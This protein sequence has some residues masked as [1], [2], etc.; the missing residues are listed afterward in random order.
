MSIQ[1]CRQTLISQDFL[2]TNYLPAMLKHY[3]SGWVIEYYVENPELLKLVR[4]RI[5]VNRIICRYDSKREAMKHVHGIV[6]ALNAKLAAGWNPFFCNDNTV[7][8]SVSSHVAMVSDSTTLSRNMG[9]STSLPTKEDPIVVPTEKRDEK[10]SSEKPSLEEERH[11]ISFNEVCTKYLEEIRRSLR[12]DTLRSYASFLKIFRE[13]VENK[14]GDAKCSDLSRALVVEFMENVYNRRKGRGGKDIS[15]RTYNG[16][17]KQGS[18]FFSWMID[19]C[20]IEDNHFSKI[21]AKRVG[22]KER[23]LIP[24][25]VREKVADYLRPRDPNYLLFLQ[26]IFAGLIRPKELGMLKVG[27]LSY[28]QGNIR[29]RSEVAKNG[30]E[31]IVPLSVDILQTFFNLR[32]HEYPSSYYIFGEG[33]KPTA[34][35]GSQLAGMKKWAKVRKAL[36]LPMEMQQYS[37][38]DTGITEMIKGGIDPLTVQ[39]L[40]DHSSLAVTSVYTKHKDPNLHEIIT[41]NAPKFTQ[42]DVTSE[43]KV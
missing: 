9:S 7:S 24:E 5:K 39:Q 30:H 37:F 13:W 29:V 15:P 12:P 25:D 31:R 20:Y 26:L 34:K 33:F 16:Y 11:N 43:V 2:V 42:C 4:K 27:D 21:K 18:A 35:R 40:A 32:I 3:D 1:N 23:E 38:R 10:K 41:K 19:K 14:I 8:V 28:A 6:L 17:I 36:N 22:N